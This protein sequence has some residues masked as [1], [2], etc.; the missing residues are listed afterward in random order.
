MTLAIWICLSAPLA[1]LAVTRAMRREMTPLQ[2]AFYGF[3]AGTA[4]A[5]AMY[6]IGEV[7]AYLLPVGQMDVYLAHRLHSLWPVA[8]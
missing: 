1:M 6:F 8:R 3:A 4:A 2:R 5:F 7:L